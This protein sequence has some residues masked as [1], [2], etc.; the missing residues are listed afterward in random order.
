MSG[1][2]DQASVQQSLFSRRLLGDLEAIG[3][4][5]YCVSSKLKTVFVTYPPV[6]CC[7]TPLEN[8][9]EACNRFLYE[10]V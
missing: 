5:R 4:D 8:K 1:N 3:L 10:V 2:P 9:A 7:W 6:H